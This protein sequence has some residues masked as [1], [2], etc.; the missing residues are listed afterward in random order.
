MNPTVLAAIIGVGGTAIVGVAGFWASVKNTSKNTFLAL[1]AVELTEQTQVTDRYSTAIQHLGSENLAVRIGGIYALERIARDSGR[2]HPAIMDVLTAFIREE[3]RKPQEPESAASPPADEGEDHE[4][5]TPRLLATRQEFEEL[6]RRVDATTRP[7]VQAAV[8][9]IGRRDPA[10]D[11][12]LIDLRGADLSGADLSGAHLAGAWLD[13]ATFGMAILVNANLADAM[14]TW[15][16]LDL[17]DLDG[18]DFTGTRLDGADLS[19]AD[20]TST[21]AF[22]PRSLQNVRLT[23]AN[24]SGLDLSGTNMQTANLAD[25]DCRQTNLA[26]VSLI[27]ADLPRAKLSGANLRDADL[28]SADWQGADFTGADLTGVLLEPEWPPPEGWQRDPTSGRLR[29]A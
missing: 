14:L 25:A 15:A 3:S 9:V 5:T 6:S 29:P 23:R 12:G 17:A 10:N 27:N 4:P 28:R 13:R 1:R 22:R 19:R 21:R 7:D 24:L 8:T 11:K 18:V 20:L 26:G 16:D 2:D